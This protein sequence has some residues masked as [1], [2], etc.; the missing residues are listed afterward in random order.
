[1]SNTDI[2]GYKYS[3]ATSGCTDEYLQPA[4]LK[5]LADFKI[6]PCRAFDLGCGNGVVTNWL[7]EQGFKTCGVDPS[8]TGIATARRAFPTADLHV[9]SAYD[10]L[11]ESFGTFPLVISLEVVEHVYAPRT[12]ARCIRN[13]LAPNG[14]ALISTP[15]HGYLKNLT[16]AVTGKMDVHFTALWDHGHIKFWSRETLSTLLT[17]A[18]LSVLRIDRIGRIPQLAKSMLAIVQNRD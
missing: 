9:G 8:P 14:Y 5:A 4:I 16:L 15:Y 13:L 6:A 3:E 11:H 18:G 17:D 10:P 2:S 7:S 12:Y 1:M